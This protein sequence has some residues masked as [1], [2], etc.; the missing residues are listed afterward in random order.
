MRWPARARREQLGV[1]LEATATPSTTAHYHHGARAAWAEAEPLYQRA[2]AIARRRSAPTTPTVATSLNN[3]AELLPGPGPLR[4]GRAALQARPGDRREGARPGP[5]RRRHQ[6]QQPGRAVPEP[7]PLRRGRAALQARPG[8]PR[9]GARARPPRHRHRASTTW[10]CS[11]GP[12]PLRR[13]RAA[14]QARPG[15]PREGARARPPRLSPP[16]STT[17]PCCTGTRAAT[18]RP[19][20]S[21]SAPLAIREKS[22]GRTIPTWR[23]SARTTPASSTEFGRPEEAAV[24][25]ARAGRAPR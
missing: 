8:D 17:W 20:R 7:G 5:P 15:D 12:G 11:T 16:G 18:P 25:R 19:S 1:A 21:T 6:P 9:E 23:R 22:L 4:R 2:L 3:L 10:R 13:G 14:L 24:L